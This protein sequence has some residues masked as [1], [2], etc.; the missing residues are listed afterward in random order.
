MNQNRNQTVIKSGYLFILV[1]FLLAIFNIIV[2]LISNSITIVS[3]ALHSL[4]DTI[5]GIL[6]IISEK[7]ANH[8]KFN[9]K[10]V[11]IE[12]ATT[13]IIAIII[14]T[15][16]IHII[17]DAYEA[18]ISPERVD[19]SPA[20]IIVLIASIVAKYLLAAYLKNTGKKIKSNVLIASSTETM[21]DALISIAVLASAIIYLVWHVNLEAYLSI[22]IAIVIIKV[23]LEFIFPHL[24][25][26]HHHH[27]ET[28]S[29]HDHCHKK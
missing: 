29:D 2:G 28:D 11:Q 24:S 26:H 16:G 4:T 14:M 12:R 7:L 8:K 15:V 9:Q 23:G 6:V 27:L 19:Y 5:S 18:L 13:I 25:K 20:V 22:I 21:N 3:D 1:N 17:I 10:R